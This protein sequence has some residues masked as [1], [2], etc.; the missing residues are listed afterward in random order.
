MR[1]LQLAVTA[2]ADAYT[3]SAAQPAF[4]LFERHYPAL[5]A[6]GTFRDSTDL[7]TAFG[8]AVLDRAVLDALCRATRTSVY[9]AFQRNLV[10]L[11]DTA[12]AA[13]MNDWNWSHWLG[14][15]APSAT[16]HARHTVGMLDALDRREPRWR[17][18]RFAAGE[19]ARRRAPL[20]PSLFQDQ[21]R[22]PRGH[23]P[24]AARCRAGR[25]GCR[26]AGPSLHARRQRAICRHRHAGRIVRRPA[27]AATA[28]GA[29]RRPA[30]H[31][32]TAGPRCQHVGG[33]ALARQPRAIAARRSRWH[34][35][36]LSG[37]VRG[38]MGR[39][40]EQGL[41]GPVQV[42]HQPRP[43]R[44]VEC[45]RRRGR[46]Q[47]LLHVG[48]GSHL[49][50]RGFRAA[51]P[52]AGSAAGPRPHASATAITTSTDSAARRSRNRSPSPSRTPGSVRS[53]FRPRAAAHPR[54]PHRH[55][56]ARAHGLRMRR[57]ARLVDSL[58]ATG[59]ARRCSSSRP[60]PS[61]PETP[62]PWL[63]N[64]SESSCTA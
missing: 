15:L 25:A 24:G 4:S 35:R 16:L 38:G 3:H 37:R 34:A 14:T 49:P 32:A 6:E 53:R 18:A 10:G 59:G 47:A 42:G 36:R 12:V 52:G 60:H 2:A 50:G 48:R 29:A 62:D 46:W 41:Q 33:L 55:R 20:R 45:G 21:A 27:C 8:Q 9:G 13:D 30:L 19:P 1:D 57:R 64:D 58:Q 17:R 40:V 31:R 44:Q 23:R 5:M 11:G 28:G 51:G 26:A 54:R 63:R 43:L 22:R 56:L 39:G 61:T 7:S